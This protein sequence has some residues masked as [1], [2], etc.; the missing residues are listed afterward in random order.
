MDYEEK[1][2]KARFDWIYKA[3]EKHNKELIERGKPMI[4]D[5]DKQLMSR[6][7]P[8]NY[9]ICLIKTLISFFRR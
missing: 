6:K 5:A 7:G 3:E 2:H 4:M 8:G 1:K 9:L